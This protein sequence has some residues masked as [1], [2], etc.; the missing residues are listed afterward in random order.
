MARYDLLVKNGTI[1]LPGSGPVRADLAV[2][3]GRIGAVGKEYVVEDQNGG[4]L[5]ITDTGMTE[6]PRS[7]HLLSL[8]PPDSVT[9]AM[10]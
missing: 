2:K 7:S 5:V 3:D 10:L 6:E 8:L 1:V 4:R 9:I